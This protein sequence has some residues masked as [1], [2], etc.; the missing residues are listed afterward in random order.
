MRI[1]A[2][3]QP[4]ATP[5]HAPQ[6][7]LAQPSPLMVQEECYVCDV[8]VRPN[9]ALLRRLLPPTPTRPGEAWASRARVPSSIASHRIDRIALPRTFPLSAPPK[10]VQVKLDILW[11]RDFGA[12]QL[13]EAHE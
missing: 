11:L 8:R 6:N 7:I 2:Q 1:C 10:R 12:A 9:A 4:L 5:T 3:L 13:S